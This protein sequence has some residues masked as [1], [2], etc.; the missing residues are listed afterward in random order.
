MAVKLLKMEIFAYLCQMQVRCCQ[1]FR[2][3]F[4]TSFCSID[5]KM[6]PKNLQKRGKSSNFVG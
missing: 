3:L 4:W 6:L 5:I 1:F 2:F